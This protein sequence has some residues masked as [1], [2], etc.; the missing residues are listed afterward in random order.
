MHWYLIRTKPYQESRVQFHM[1]Q[2]SLEAFLPL[3]KQK[4]T[5]RRQHKVVVGPLFPQYLFA[6]FDISERYRAVNFSRGVANIVQF[7]SKPAEVSEALING[8]KSRMQNGYITPKVERFQN[9]QIV[10]IKRGPLAGLEA[11]FLREMT[12][13]DRVILLLKSLGFNARITADIDHVSLAQAL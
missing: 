10:R 4:K 2:L 1:R 6:R 12:D 7:G 13:Q 5:I 9:G 8:I 3:L 11:V